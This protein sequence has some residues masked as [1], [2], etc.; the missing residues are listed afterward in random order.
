MPFT[1]DEYLESLR[2]GREVYVYGERVKDVTAHPAFRNTAR[3]DR[4]AVRRPA[5][6][7]PARDADDRDR[8]RQRRPHA[9]VLPVPAQRRGLRRR[10]RRDRRVGAAEL[11]LAGT[12]P[13][14]QGGVPGTLGANADFYEPYQE[15]AKRWYREAQER[16]LY[17]NHAIIHPPVDRNR[18]LDEVGDVFMHVEEERDDG[19]RRQRGQG[20]RHRLGA[21]ALQLHRPLR[22]GAGAEEGVRARLRGRDGHA[23][24]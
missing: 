5:R 19:H 18:P 14:L 1:G 3:I 10:P 21:H 11:R 15:N 20:R 23:R 4:A 13:R 24:A 7:P 2:D 16:V 22:P 8:H 6:R 9:Q 17:W 12:Q